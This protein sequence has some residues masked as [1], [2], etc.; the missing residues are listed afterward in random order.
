MKKGANYRSFFLLK[1]LKISISV[2]L[3]LLIVEFDHC[4]LIQ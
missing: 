1:S 3:E 4:L 2:I